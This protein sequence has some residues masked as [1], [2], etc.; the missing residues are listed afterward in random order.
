MPQKAIQAKNKYPAI[1]RPLDE[2]M[3]SVVAYRPGL[4]L[5]SPYFPGKKTGESGYNAD[6]LE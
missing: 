5:D 6:R 2:K 3:L 4:F 1:V